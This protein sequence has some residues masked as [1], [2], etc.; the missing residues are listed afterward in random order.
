MRLKTD[1]KLHLRAD[2]VSVVFSDIDE[3]KEG[4]HTCKD[5][6]LC[7]NTFGKYECK[8]MTCEAGFEKNG[9]MDCVGKYE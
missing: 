7:R 4:L 1:M 8:S 5:T 2:L 9:N 6:E 3:C